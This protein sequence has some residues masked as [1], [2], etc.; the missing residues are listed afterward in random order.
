M[1][2]RRKKVAASAVDTTGNVTV[3]STDGR[4]ELENDLEYADV[5]KCLDQL[6]R[7]VHPVLFR[8]GGTGERLHAPPPT[9]G[10]P[11]WRGAP[12]R[13]SGKYGTRGGKR[14]RANKATAATATAAASS[15][16]TAAASSNAAA[17]ASHVGKA[18]VGKGK[19]KGKAGS[20]KGICGKGKNK[21]KCNKGGKCKS[22]NADGDKG[23]G[24]RAK[25]N[26]FEVAE[27][28]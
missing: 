24:K 2:W 12:L 9:D 23:T 4:T 10:R 15:S 19:G 17:S 27:P 13:A 8:D 20:D 5:A 22:G 26:A 21:G 28:A 7:A 3:P 18:N 1:P 6:E 25:D 11:T 16:G 14:S